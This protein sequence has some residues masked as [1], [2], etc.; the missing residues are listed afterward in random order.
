[1]PEPK[2]TPEPDIQAIFNLAA[3]QVSNGIPPAGVEQNLID[4]GLSA[5]VAT[6]IVSKLMQA[7]TTLHKE[8]GQRN[9]LFGALWCIGGIIVTVL[10]YQAAAGAGGGKYVIAWGAI[11][12]G[13]IQFFR[14]VSQASE[15]E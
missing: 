2:Q 10:T 1:M 4:Q 8:A 12:F 5:E 11:V 13:A 6:I 15:T 7:R 9:M 14:G 3:H